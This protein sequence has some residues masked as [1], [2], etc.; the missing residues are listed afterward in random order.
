[1]MSMALEVLDEVNF[2]TLSKV[3][4][5]FLV[6]PFSMMEIEMVIKKCD[7]NKSLGPDGF[8]FPFF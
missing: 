2:A 3:D 4:N 1:M 5:G 6:T 8:N 7:R